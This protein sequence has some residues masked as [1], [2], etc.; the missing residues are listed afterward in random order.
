MIHVNVNEA[1]LGRSFLKKIRL[2]NVSLKNVAKAAFA[3]HL[4]LSKKAQGTVAK[5]AFAPHLL[6]KNKKKRLVRSNRRPIT[7]KR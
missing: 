1:G 6:L 4:L 3:P 2:K 7:L 5:A